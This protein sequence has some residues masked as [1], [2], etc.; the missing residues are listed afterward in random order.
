LT[1]KE[2]LRQ[3]RYRLLTGY[4][5]VSL[6]VFLIGLPSFFQFIQN[7]PGITLNDSVLQSL[8]AV[9][10]SIPIF[11]L[12]YGAIIVT[13]AIHFRH[14]HF[15]LIALATY[16]TANYLRILTIYLFT[17]EPPMGVVTLHDPF[18][19]LIAY[20]TSTFA[21][22]LFFSGHVSTLLVLVYPEPNSR[23]R[24]IKLVIT[25]IVAMLLLV[26]HIHYTIDILAAPLFTYLAYKGTKIIVRN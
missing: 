1:W 18:V 9:D 25:L 2:A 3:N 12:I 15:I 8:P 20:D 22:D 23:F 19:S 5:I 11:T 7:K 17:L 24:I 6:L 21:K 4:I 26:Q 14:P 10:L 13:I 16:C